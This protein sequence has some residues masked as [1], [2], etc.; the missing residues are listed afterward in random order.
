MS[1]TKDQQMPSNPQVVAITTLKETEGPRIE[2]IDPEHVDSLA[3]NIDREGLINAISVTDSQESDYEYEIIDGRHRKHALEQ[4]GVENV[5]VYDIPGNR[6]WVVPTEEAEADIGI[7]SMAANVLRKEQTQAEEARFLKYTIDTRVI[8]EFSDEDRKKLGKN[9]NTDYANA[10]VNQA[11]QLL[12]HKENVERGKVDWKFSNK[13]LNELTRI[14]SAADCAPKT[15]SEHIRFYTNSPQDVVNAWKQDDITKGFIKH[16]RQIDQDDLRTHALERS[17]ASGD[18]GYSTRDM[19]T[20]KKI[21]NCDAPKTHKSL[22]S[23]KISDLDDALEQA[24]KEEEREDS[25]ESEPPEDGTE[26]VDED[27]FQKFKQETLTPKDREQAERITDYEDGLSTEE[28]FKT[29]YQI[30]QD[31]DDCSEALTNAVEDIDDLER[32]MTERKEKRQ[33]ALN[34]FDF[35]T[36]SAFAD[37]DVNHLA[38]PVETD[39]FGVFFHDVQEMDDEVDKGEL[40]LIFTSPP[41][42][43]QSD[44]IVERWWPEDVEYTDENI[45]ESTVDSAYQNYLDEMGEIFQLLNAKL[46]QGRY[47]ILNISDTKSYGLDTKGYDIPSDLSHLIRHEVN[48]NL[49]PENQ[50][51]YDATIA[52]DKGKGQTHDRNQS[53]FADG[54]P[55]TYHPNWRYERLLVFRKGKRSHPDTDFQLDTSKFQPY[56][57]DVW[58]IDNKTHTSD[59]EAGFTAELPKE[60]LS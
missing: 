8:D 53:F 12:D 46:E 49:E 35:A 39:N 14:L 26:D 11:L 3:D 7:Q 52:W 54:K 41:Y 37:G 44:R 60:S 56:S 42:F 10:R 31:G 19:R 43:T 6:Y 33:N 48:E 5:A 30:D 15:A 13:H 4:L 22:I 55:L 2:P 38:P 29:C 32:E 16:L 51:K 18:G 50:F 57:D 59:H 25:P 1:S 34:D 24:K 21:A 17:K 58:R 40:Q 28:V 20:V 36:D 27:K 9:S 45:T 47:M 23:G